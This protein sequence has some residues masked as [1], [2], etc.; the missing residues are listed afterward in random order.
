MTP[1]PLPPNEPASNA[2][3]EVRLPHTLADG[4]ED[5]LEHTD[6]AKLQ[7]AAQAWNRFNDEHGSFADEFSTL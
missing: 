4:F 2:G 3:E 6:E 7:R 5:P 1:S